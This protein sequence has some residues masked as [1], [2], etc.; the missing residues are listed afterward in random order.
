MYII[1]I[2]L[3]VRRVIFQNV[4]N[5]PKI[6]FLELTVA[7]FEPKNKQTYFG[8][9]TLPHVYPDLATLL[10]PIVDPAKKERT[11]QK[12]KRKR[13]TSQPSSKSDMIF[14]C[15]LSLAFFM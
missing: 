10:L 7:H 6:R 11:K 12:E 1:T 13:I 14:S 9:T 8:I 5:P 2:K 4:R 15:T 3:S